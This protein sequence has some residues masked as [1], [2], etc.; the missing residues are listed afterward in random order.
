MIISITLKHNLELFVQ[1]ERKKIFSLD[2]LNKLSTKKLWAVLFKAWIQNFCLSNYIFPE[3]T[4]C[5]K[6]LI[7]HRTISVLNNLLVTNDKLAGIT[8]PYFPINTCAEVR[9]LVAWTTAG[10]ALLHLRSSFFKHYNISLKSHSDLI[11]YYL[12]SPLTE[13]EV[14]WQSHILQSTGKSL[15]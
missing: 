13:G 1:E 2:S 9:L 5:I 6:V 7:W 10:I 14:L 15:K 11:K 12:H 4:T 3:T 8:N